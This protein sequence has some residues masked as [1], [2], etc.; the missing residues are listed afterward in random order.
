MCPMLL[1]Y[2]FS[3]VDRDAY[4]P[5]FFLQCRP[6]LRVSC[7]WCSTFVHDVYWRILHVN[8][9]ESKSSATSLIC[10]LKFTGPV[11]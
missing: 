9:I 11:A 5:N 1:I 3:T 7:S 8:H 2:H 10:V 4:W 6:I